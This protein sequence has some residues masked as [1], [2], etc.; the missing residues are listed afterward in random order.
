MKNTQFPPNSSP[1][2]LTLL[3]AAAAPSES[4]DAFARF[5]DWQ[6]R[7]EVANAKIAGLEREITAV[8][9]EAV[10]LRA[11]AIAQARN[12]AAVAERRI[13]Q[14]A[15]AHPEWREGKSIRSPL[16]RVEF[17]NV[18]RLHPIHAE[19]SVLLIETLVGPDSPHESLRGWRPEHLLAVEK[20]LR[21][22]VLE[23]LPDGDLHLLG[24]RRL[25]NEIVTVKP[26]NPSQEFSSAAAAA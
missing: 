11:D 3:P 17:R 21:L 10:A 22:E 16:G 8:L 6:R 4:A 2:N 12:E 19:A 20:R 13:T 26:A 7:H 15:V 14:L 24:I 9:G 5:L 25:R 18:H 23:A 1:S